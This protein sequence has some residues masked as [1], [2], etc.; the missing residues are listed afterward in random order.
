MNEQ[1]LKEIYK[2]L[3][4]KCS[5]FQFLKVSLSEICG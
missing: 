5:T 3:A 1:Q 2:Q 4:N